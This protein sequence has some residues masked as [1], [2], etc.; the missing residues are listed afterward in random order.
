MDEIH[1]MADSGASAS[2]AMDTL[3]PVPKFDDILILGGQLAHPPKD[4]N[5][6]VDVGTV[7]GPNAERP[8][9]LDAPVFVSHMSFGALSKTAKVALAKGSAM[10]RTAMCSGEGGVLPEEMKASYKYIYEYPPNGYSFT[11]KVLSGSSAIEI[12]IGQGT[13]PGMGGHLPGSKVT[14]EIAAMRGK[15]EGQDILSPSRFPGIETPEDLKK[16]VD[17]LRERGKGI[18]VGVKIAAGRIEDDLEFI[19]GSGCDFITIDGRGGATG[20]SPKFLRDATS[21][22]TVYAL[23]RARKY[24]DEHG[25]EQ[26]LIITGGLRTSADVVKAVAMG[27][28]AVAMASAPLMALGCQRYRACNSGKCPMGIA[29]QDPEL[30]SRLD[31]EA[32]AVRVGNF[33]NAMIGE[34]RSFVRITGHDSLVEMSA[35]DLC[36]TDPSISEASGIRHA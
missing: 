19:S 29:T 12:K 33:L 17:M 31:L 30:E 8:M 32:G 1:A 13:K 36:T 26:S 23:I 4:E 5:A 15:P 34:I 20:S 9:V 6:D 11:D 28:D 25:M 21:V 35:D 3:L 14:P 2:A 27:A 24:M 22:P 10:A 16:L 7:I 18:P